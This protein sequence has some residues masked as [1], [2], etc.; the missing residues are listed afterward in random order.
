MLPEGTYLIVGVGLVFLYRHDAQ[1]V[2]E[3]V[4]ST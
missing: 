4:W 2:T 3:V 1:R